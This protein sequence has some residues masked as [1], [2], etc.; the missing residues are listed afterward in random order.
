MKLLQ[1][2]LTVTSAIVGVLAVAVI[3]AT[4]FAFPV[5]W[6]WNYA[7][8]ETF[9]LP[10]INVWQALCLSFLAGAFFKNTVK[11]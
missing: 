2:I 10:A 4:M 1:T 9:G 5:K 7:M 11:K 8:V 3:M 6:A